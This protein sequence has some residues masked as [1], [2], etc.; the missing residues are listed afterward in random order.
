MQQLSGQPSDFKFLLLN[1]ITFDL[2]LNYNLIFN[3]RKSYSNEEP[4]TVT[5]NDPRQFLTRSPVLDDP[6]NDF[7]LQE[8]TVDQF[9][10]EDEATSLQFEFFYRFKVNDNIWITPGFFFVTNPGHIANNDTIYVATIRTTFR[11]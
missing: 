10:R 8:G 3:Q 7:L 5:D 6:D 2:T 4:V 9:G 11:F 1:A